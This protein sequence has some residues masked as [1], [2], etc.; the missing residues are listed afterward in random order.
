MDDTVS[1]AL[2]EAWPAMTPWR[3]E[4]VTLTPLPGCARWSLRVPP[5]GGIA[6]GFALGM[7]INRCTVAGERLAAR[8]GPDE[9]LLCAP[10]AQAAEIESAVA[11]ALAGTAH[12]LVDVSHRY[13]ALA[14]EGAQAGGMLAAGCPLDLHPAVFPVGAA[15]RTLL[16]KAEIV[17][18]RPDPAGWRVECARSFAPY[19]WAFLGEAAREFAP[20]AP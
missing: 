16:G 7:A 8:L 20:A 5:V 6:A 17:L 19:V 15:T 3:G 9:W 4:G 11:P 13:A 1:L 10:P 2:T 14:I 12:A 18:W